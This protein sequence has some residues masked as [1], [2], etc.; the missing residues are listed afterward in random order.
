MPAQQLR[1]DENKKEIPAQ[2]LRKCRNWK[3]TG[4]RL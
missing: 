3:E 2:Q 1:K 4:D